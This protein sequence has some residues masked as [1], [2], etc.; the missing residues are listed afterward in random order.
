M[1]YTLMVQDILDIGYQTVRE[2]GEAGRIRADGRQPDISTRADL[3]V[4]ERV[5]DYLK[6]KRFQ[7]ALVDEEH[8][9]REVDGGQALAVLDDI[10]GTANFS[11]GA[12]VPAVTIIGFCEPAVP[13]YGQTVAA[14]MVDLRN[15]DRWTA[16][17]GKGL[18]YQKGGVG[19]LVQVRTSGCR[20]PTRG[21]SQIAV[22]LYQVKDW[23]TVGQI[24]KMAKLQDYGSSGF[25]AAMVASGRLD[26][27]IGGGVTF[28]EGGA[29]YLLV[30]E[31]GGWLADLE[32][33]PVD[34]RVMEQD[35]RYP[36]LAAATPELGRMLAGL[37]KAFK[38]E[39]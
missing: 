11:R 34:N 15:G 18:W 13:G 1:V 30:K 36:L 27:F 38:A 2:V 33:N 5:F 10:D 12:D 32:G 25:H 20:E 4:G 26:A 24:G 16:E 35:K 7:G 23:L 37:L 3:L 14:G 6:Q 39:I 31:A 28:V 22:D 8:G 17:R 21:T 19:E 29:I 9:R